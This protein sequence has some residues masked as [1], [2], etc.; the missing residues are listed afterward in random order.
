MP[1]QDVP[2][3]PVADAPPA[4][5]AA[6]PDIAAP[7]AAA[8]PIPA[9]GSTQ[10]A[11]MAAMAKPM[12]AQQAATQ[13][14]A[15]IAAQSTAPPPPGPHARLLQMISGLATGLGA[16]STSIA[17]HGREGGAAEVQQVQ[18]AE[19]QQKQQAQAAREA[20]KNQ[21]IQQQLMVA[22]TNHKLAQNI[23]FMSTVK[24]EMTSSDLKVKGEKLG[25][26]GQTQDI[27]TKALQD[28]LLTGDKAAFD[29]TLQDIGATTGTPSAPAAGATGGAAIPPVATSQWKNSVDT[30]L[31]AYPNDPDIKAAHD[32]YDAALKADDP[33]AASLAMAS[34]AT[35]AKN[36][37]S[38]LDA[39]AKSRTEQQAAAAGARPKDLND[40]VGRL[41]QAQQGYAAD[42]TPANKLL[43]DN[44]KDAR[45]AFIS[46]EG[47]L[48]RIKQAAQDGDPTQLAAGLVHGDVAWSQVVSSRKP[49]FAT[50]A[51]KAANDLSMKETGKPFSTEINE[52]NFKQATD[53]KVQGTLRMIE[54]MIEPNGSISIARDAFNSIPD[55]IDSKTFNN[56]MSG[57]QAQFGGKS[58]IAFRTAVTGLADEYSQVMAGPGGTETTRQQALNII[59]QGYSK[60]QG[61]T[62]LETMQQDINAR[63][64]ALT[65]G[66]PALQQMFPD[67]KPRVSSSGKAVSLATAMALPINKGKTEQQVRDDITAHGHQVGQ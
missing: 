27:R 13:R 26:I 35:S 48:A 33:Q 62:A 64:K 38:A 57:V 16:A 39:G 1:D 59:Q 11:T 47:S 2:T 44:A 9:T 34:A 37:M 45:D 14:A 30:A 50:A 36:R 53:P 40:A 32:R 55:K 56:I 18:A 5:P 20:T 21:Q 3:T 42:S 63:K 51:L 61:A 41:A 24:N 22:D 19:A 4:V 52:V 46:A 67:T 43:V 31:S 29:K 15:D 49:E 7:V 58:I 8:P 28:F 60:G 12:A 17:T 54:S 10:D 23:L 66:N 65:I 6:A 25:V